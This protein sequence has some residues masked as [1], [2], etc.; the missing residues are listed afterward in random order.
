MIN[1]APTILFKITN[2][3][4]DPLKIEE[5]RLPWKNRYSATVAL[6][7]RKSG[8]TARPKFRI[9]DNFGSRVL[10]LQPGQTIDG[11]MSLERFVIDARQFVDKNEGVVFWYYQPRDASNQ[12]LGEYGGWFKA[13]TGP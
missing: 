4:R 6:V 5:V 13:P 7:D 1:G 2:I 12:S 11:A 10:E 9:E 3:G 8:D